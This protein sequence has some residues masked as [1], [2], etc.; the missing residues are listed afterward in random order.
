MSAER[1]KECGKMLAQR[2]QRPSRPLSFV[3]NVLQ[4]YRTTTA[5]MAI[6]VV[7]LLPVCTT[8]PRPVAHLICLR[9]SYALVYCL[10]FRF[11][12]FVFCFV[13]IFT[14]SIVWNQLNSLLSW[15]FYC[16]LFAFHFSAHSFAHWM[17]V[18][19]LFNFCAPAAQMDFMPDFIHTYCL[20]FENYFLAFFADIF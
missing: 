14:S 13:F 17:F 10:F 16:S 3:A 6:V 2:P 8:Q 20:L 4:H 7:K 5:F 19:F 11:S 9:W 12:F 1:M 18:S 15:N